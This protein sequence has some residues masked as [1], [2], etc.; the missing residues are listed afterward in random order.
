MTPLLFVGV[1]LA[2]GLGAGA[3]L[4]VDALVRTRIRSHFP[5]GTILI[6]VTGAFLLG[7][8]VALTVAR[9]LPPEWQLVLG[10]GLLGGYTTFSTAS[11]ETVRLLQER[12]YGFAL[13]S[14][15]GM[16][17]ATV[18]AAALGLWLGSLA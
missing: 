10:T 4:Y 7:L 8:V 9:V 2:G 14:S 11:L 15:V 12:R 6:N 18:C 5:Y 16:L 3:R 17:L 1:A 13:A